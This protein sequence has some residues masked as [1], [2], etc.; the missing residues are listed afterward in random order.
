MVFR[1][2]IEKIIEKKIKKNMSKF[3]KKGKDIT[4]SFWWFLGKNIQDKNNFKKVCRAMSLYYI[5]H[6][7]I[8]LMSQIN[9]LMVVG[10]TVFIYTGRP[11]IVIGSGG[12]CV[13]ELERMINYD[14]IGEKRFINHYYEISLIE[15][16]VS[17]IKNITENIKS[18]MI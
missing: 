1:E 2:K 12:Q 10:N 3:R 14:Y 15:D 8:F 18:N 6:Q 11:G 17:G 9:D 7:N 5:Q 13:D 4:Y 16:M